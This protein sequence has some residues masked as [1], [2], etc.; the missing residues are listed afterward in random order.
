MGAWAKCSDIMWEEVSAD[1]IQWSVWVYWC[2]LSHACACGLMNVR[3]SHT[4]KRYTWNC[5]DILYWPFH[6]ALHVCAS[7]YE[8][9]MS[10]LNTN[11]Q[12]R[13]FYKPVAS[14]RHACW[15]IVTLSGD[16]RWCLFKYHLGGNEWDVN[17]RRNCVMRN[18]AWDVKGA[19]ILSVRKWIV[20]LK[21]ALSH[22][23]KYQRWAL[24]YHNMSIRVCCMCGLPHDKTF[25]SYVII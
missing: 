13:D 25:W 4:R 18:C 6:I 21:Y 11:P 14:I 23:M 10:V 19:V 16:R 12:W 5:C 24:I 22:S 2:T 17:V 1:V 3:R 8:F 7:I 15:D 20:F 9:Y